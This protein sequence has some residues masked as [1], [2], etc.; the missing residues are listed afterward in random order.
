MSCSHPLF[1]VDRG[2]KENGKRD[3]IFAT[4]VSSNLG[5]SM[6]ELKA[7]YGDRLVPVPCGKCVGCQLDHS[8]EWATRCVLESLDYEDNSF[9]TLTYAKEPRRLSKRAVQLFMK[10]VRKAHP[11]ILI[12]FFACGE[13]GEKSGRRHY[14]VLLFG[15]GFPDK[16][17]YNCIEGNDYYTSYELRRLW[18]YGISIIGAVSKQSAAYVARYTMK[19]QGKAKDPEEFILM[20]R[21]PGIGYKWFS[22]HK[23]VI[24]LS[25]H[26]YG[27]FGS[28]HVASVPKY[29]DKLAE[30]N[31]LD[32]SSIKDNRIR[33]AMNYD[34]LARRLY[35]AE[36]GEALNSLFEE[37]L[38]KR[39][40]Y[41][42]RNL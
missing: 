36:A 40:K 8:K 30:K 37:L 14:H 38:L 25:D 20:S 24:Y 1:M 28:S 42:R 29:F 9:L 11:D 15:Y 18:P 2:V 7:R 3:L 19:K 32:L 16:Q 26:I 22:E 23:D 17:F 5:L 6:D 41:L 31:G 34:L 4:Q 12:R 13:K 27:D 39:I 35:H 21:N 33:L 10:R